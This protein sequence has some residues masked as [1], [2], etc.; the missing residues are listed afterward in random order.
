[1]RAPSKKSKKQRTAKRALQVLVTQSE[2]VPEAGSSQGDSPPD[3]VMEG[4]DER[5][6]DS[7]ETPIESSQMPA[8][9]GEQNLPSRNTPEE[10][11]GRNWEPE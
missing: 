2:T 11:S 1:M 4:L 7:I 6:A 8:L 9:D 5:A 10:K 3:E